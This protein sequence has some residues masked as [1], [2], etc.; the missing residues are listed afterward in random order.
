MGGP[1]AACQVDPIGHLHD[2]RSAVVERAGMPAWGFAAA[3]HIVI[4]LGTKPA[5][6]RVIAVSSFTTR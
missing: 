3:P 4:Q 6:G 1:A 2:H 5:L